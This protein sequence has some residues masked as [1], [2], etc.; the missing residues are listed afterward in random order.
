MFKRQFS[1]ERIIYSTNG[2]G[3]TRYPHT[4]IIMVVVGIIIIRLSSI[5]NTIYKN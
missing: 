3:I 1:E 2:A 4:K 5:P